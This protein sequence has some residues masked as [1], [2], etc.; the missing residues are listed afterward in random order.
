MLGLYHLIW[1]MISWE[2]VG[3]PYPTNERCVSLLWDGFPPVHS[4]HQLVNS[5]AA[6]IEDLSL[7][8]GSLFLGISVPSPP[9]CATSYKYSRTIKTLIR[10][11][12]KALNLTSK[13]LLGPCQSALHPGNLGNL[14]FLPVALSTGDDHRV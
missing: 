11:Q 13:Y 4:A 14:L 12:T 8:A 1:W 5:S 10:G 6:G 7:L 2:S 9:L 3:N